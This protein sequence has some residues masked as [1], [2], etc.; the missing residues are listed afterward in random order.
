[1]TLPQVIL[2]RD[3]PSRLLRREPL[4]NPALRV[5][6]GEQDSLQGLKDWTFPKGRVLAEPTTHWLGERGSW[7]R[8]C[9]SWAVSSF[10]WHLQLNLG[11]M[12]AESSVSHRHHEIV[13]FPGGRCPPSCPRG[14]LTVPLLGGPKLYS[15]PSLQQPSPSAVPLIPEWPKQEVTRDC[16]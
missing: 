8:K 1:M 6:E 2:P 16:K 12:L 7:A 4:G 11:L 3:G 5:R 9:M 15:E 14:A 10:L 13:S